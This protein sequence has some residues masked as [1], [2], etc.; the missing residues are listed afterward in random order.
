MDKGISLVVAS[1]PHSEAL[2]GRERDSKHTMTTIGLLHKPL[3]P[4]GK[5]QL[6][7]AILWVLVGHLQGFFYR[8]KFK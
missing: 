4:D 5:D 8:P 6:V 7:S 3:G 2:K 1:V